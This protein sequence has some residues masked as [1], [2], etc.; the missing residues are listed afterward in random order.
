MRFVYAIAA[1]IIAAVMILTGLAQRTVFLGPSAVRSDV[2]VSGENPYMVIDGSVLTSH[3]GQQSL[4]VTGADE[5]F[6]AYGRTADVMAWLGQAGASYDRV[7]LTADPNSD[8]PIQTTS[9]TAEP[10]DGVDVD[11]E[12]NPDPRGSDL[13][14]SETS[15]DLSALA[16]MSVDEDKSVLIAADGVEAVPGE[17]KLSWPLDNSTPW[18]G[19]LIAGGLLMLA[20]GIVL[21]ILAFVHHKRSRGPRRRGNPELTDGSGRRRLGGRS[22][23][24]SMVAVT[25]LGV[26]TAIVLSGCSPAYWPDLAPTPTATGEAEQIE[27]ALEDAAPPALTGPQLER[28]VVKVS[29][30]ATQA[31]ADLDRSLIETRFDGVA[32]ESRLASYTILAEQEERD[33]NDEDKAAAP[34]AIPASPVKLT[35]PQAVSGWPRTVFTVV[36][37]GE[38]ATVAPT[39]LVLTQN[40]PRDNYTVRRVVKLEPDASIP[41]LA[42]ATIGASLVPP[43][44][45]FLTIAPNAMAGAYADLV[46]NGE[47][48]EW[49]E[50]FPEESDALRESIATNLKKARESLGDTGELS[51]EVV[52]GESDPVAFATLN[53]G[54]LVSVDI[55]ETQKA[56]P[57]EEGV[58]LTTSGRIQL[59]SGV[60]ETTTGVETRYGDQLLFYVPPA[61]SEEKIQLLGFS[62][63]ILSSKEIE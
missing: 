30:V 44:S 40:S 26:G 47:K 31:D 10:V 33:V 51:S 19:P 8:T 24:R 29:D 53:S 3:E 34:E 13:W 60:D 21:Y 54:A 11:P 15:D 38:E 48:S 1:F 12:A 27:E 52:A 7:T 43:D 57:S 2:T 41:E 14:L 46:E 50:Y 42:P 63:D 59:L 36:N 18:A 6:L 25:G 56:T 28:I 49:A 45:S 4:T 39:A 22:R 62:Q 17:V 16:T 9:A 55:L 20:V 37:A 23:T 35:L 32:L 58:T 5:V 61:G